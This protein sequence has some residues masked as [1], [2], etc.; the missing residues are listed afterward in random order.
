MPS[1]DLGPYLCWSDGG[2]VFVECGGQPDQRP[3]VD[4]E[5]VVATPEVLNEGVATDHYARRSLS[6]EPPHRP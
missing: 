3:G 1:R 4:G 6:P 5:H 2:F